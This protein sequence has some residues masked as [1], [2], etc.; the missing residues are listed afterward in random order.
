METSWYQI[1]IIANEVYFQQKFFEIFFFTINMDYKIRIFEEKDYEA[2]ISLW[3]S[4]GLYISLSDTKKELMKFQKRNPNSFFILEV[5]N[6]IIGAVIASWDGRR[7]Y[8]NHL[9]ILPNFQKKGF[10]KLLMNK[11]YEY[12][13]TVEA[14]KIHLLVEKTN[15]DVVSYYK[16]QG[17]YVR[18]D[19]IMMTKTLRE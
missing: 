11:C 9:A 4:A 15:K 8:I 1:D 2:V 7:G 13:E 16:N 17:W 5:D 6:Q 10:G 18:D 19:L 14:V 12:Y 3:K